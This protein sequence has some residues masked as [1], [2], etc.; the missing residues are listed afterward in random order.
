MLVKCY[1][2]T[3]KIYVKL[4]AYIIKIS[5]AEAI[6][7]IFGGEVCS[8]YIRSCGSVFRRKCK[9]QRLSK[10]FIDF[11]ISVLKVVTQGHLT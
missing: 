7:L 4:S 10:V 6:V 2:K 11:L 8:A 3:S 1:N 5:L 9:P